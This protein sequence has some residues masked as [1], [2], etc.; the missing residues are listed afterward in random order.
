MRCEAEIGQGGE[1]EIEFGEGDTGREWGQEGRE[2]RIERGE[3]P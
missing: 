3:E 1:G 2:K